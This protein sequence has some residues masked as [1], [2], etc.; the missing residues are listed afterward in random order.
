VVTRII[1]LELIEA[2]EQ[3]EAAREGSARRQRRAG[4]ALPGA[5]GPVP[6]GGGWAMKSDGRCMSSQPRTDSEVR[7]G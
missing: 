1:P 5:Q 6:S 4:V 3:L 7:I 2:V